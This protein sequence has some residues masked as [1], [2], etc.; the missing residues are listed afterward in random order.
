MVLQ[1]S[2]MPFEL[3]FL[4]WTNLF[5]CQFFPLSLLPRNSEDYSGEYRLAEFSSR[6]SA[7]GKVTKI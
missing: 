2:E 3:L 7:G 5:K 4:S 1:I 6:D